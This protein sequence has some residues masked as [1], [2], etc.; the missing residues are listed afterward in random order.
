MIMH[1]F[2]TIQQFYHSITIVRY[3]KIIHVFRLLTFG[4]NATIN[5]SKEV[6][7]L[8]LPPTTLRTEF[9]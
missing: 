2:K 1:E 7:L 9:Q 3:A 8:I 6:Y 4:I 5:A